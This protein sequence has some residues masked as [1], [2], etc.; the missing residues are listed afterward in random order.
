MIY[1]TLLKAA[2]CGL[3]PP[4]TPWSVPADKCALPHPEDPVMRKLMVDDP[5]EFKRRWKEQIGKAVGI[6][7]RYIRIDSDCLGHGKEAAQAPAAADP[8]V[9]AGMPPPV[10]IPVTSPP[11]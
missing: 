2:A 3:R 1:L 9:V 11:V 8:K 7:P 4:A 6:D 5:P 10:V